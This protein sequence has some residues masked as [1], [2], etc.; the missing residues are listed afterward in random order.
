MFGWG[1][2]LLLWIGDSLDI[3][4]FFHTS[5]ENAIDIEGIFCT[6]P[7]GAESW[8]WHIDGWKKDELFMLF[9]FGKL[10]WKCSFYIMHYCTMCEIAFSGPLHKIES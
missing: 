5:T 3:F 8:Q 1:S 4:L 10:V 2:V 6:L 9:Q 7:A